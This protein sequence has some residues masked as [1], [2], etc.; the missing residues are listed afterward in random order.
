ML[1][2]NSTYGAEI[3]FTMDEQMRG[4]ERAGTAVTNHNTLR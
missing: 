2:S 1:L 4:S 3:G